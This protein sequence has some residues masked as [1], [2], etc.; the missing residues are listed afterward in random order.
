VLEDFHGVSCFQL[1]ARRADALAGER[2]RFPSRPEKERQNVIRRLLHLP[3]VVPAAKLLQQKLHHVEDRLSTHKVI[4]ETEPALHLPGLRFKHLQPKG[5]LVL[6]LP[7]RGLPADGKL[8]AELEKL[9]QNHHEVLALDLRGLGETVPLSKSA[10]FGKDFNESFLGLLLDRP[11]LGQRVLDVLAVVRAAGRDEVHV[12]AEGVT[13]PIALHA[14]ALD[15]TIRQIT[16]DHS[17]V[18]WSN[19]AHTPIS[20]DQLSSVV[21]GVLAIYDLPD[22]AAMLAPRPLR[23]RG[24]VDAAGRSVALTELARVYQGCRERYAAIGAGKQLR[25]EQDGPR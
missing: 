7:E 11:L 21:P 12:F 13:G 24:T 8:P 20:K 6:Y 17:L 1:N 16:L 23:L 19:V 3:D 25:F 2:A 14:A 10:Y 4:Y 18:S 15:P 22:V 5:P 9:Y